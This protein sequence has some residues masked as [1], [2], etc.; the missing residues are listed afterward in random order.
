MSR[1]AIALSGNV[2][3]TL[4][5]MYSARGFNV[6]VFRRQNGQKRTT[7]DESSAVEIINTLGITVQ[8]LYLQTGDKNA[9]LSAED[10]EFIH[11]LES[12][13]DEGRASLRG[14]IRS[15]QE[16]WW[17]PLLKSR[18]T[19]TR[20]VQ[21]L[22]AQYFPAVNRKKIS[23]EKP[24]LLRVIPINIFTVL[25]PDIVPSFCKDACCAMPFVMNIPLGSAPFYSHV[26]DVD[27]LFTEYK[28]LRG[29]NDKIALSYLRNVV[30]RKE[31]RT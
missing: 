4:C 17:V 19:S 14:V 13:D 18:I 20:R 15:L 1:R 8:E 25:D 28:L 10:A 5:N 27:K 7:L 2:L 3:D 23:S 6:S 30:E 9:E 26:S 24:T 21:A 31:S 16:A 11:L 29:G 22:V 12:T